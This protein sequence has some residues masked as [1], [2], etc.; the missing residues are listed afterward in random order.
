VSAKIRLLALW[1][2]AEAL[3]EDE[4]RMLKAIAVSEEDASDEVTREAVD[5]IFGIL[6]EISKPSE[7]VILGLKAIEEAFSKIKNLLRKATARTKDALV[8]AIGVA[9]SAVT[10]ADARGFFEHAGYRSTG[11]LQ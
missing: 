3:L 5:E 2:E 1:E 4:R 8:E 11:H 7:E 9:L 10:A 6:S